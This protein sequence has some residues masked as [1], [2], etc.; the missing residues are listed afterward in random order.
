MTRENTKVVDVTRAEP[1]RLLH[2]GS[3]GS[4]THTLTPEVNRL[5]KI[6]AV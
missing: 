6:K 3:V 2:D 5:I 1:E 4:Q